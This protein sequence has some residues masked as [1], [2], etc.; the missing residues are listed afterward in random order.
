MLE[1]IP[2]FLVFA[3]VFGINCFAI[4]QKRPGLKKFLIFLG[5]VILLL[6]IGFRLNVGTDY[7]SYL[8]MY[9]RAAATPW[10]QLGTIGKEVP[11]LALFKLC[12]FVFGNGR[13]I[14]L[15]LGFFLLWPIYKI[16]KLYDYKYLAYSILVF[17]VLFLPF[18]LNGIRQGIA[19]AFM[20][21]SIVY[22]MRR[23][24]KRGIFALLLSVSFHIASLIMLP[25]IILIYV[26]EKK[27]INFTMLNILMTTLISVIIMFFLN[28]ILL[29]IGFDKYEYVLGKIN[30]E[31]VSFVNALLYLPVA[32]IALT[33]RN[34]KISDTENSVFNNLLLDGMIFCIVGS[35]ARFL[36][37]FAI[38]FLMA[39]ILLVPKQIQN[40]SEKNLR[41]LFKIL[42]I[43]YLVLLFYVEYSVLGWQEILPYQTWAFGGIG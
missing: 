34:K 4:K 24:I 35:T 22:I 20:L 33:T 17:S 38:Y 36:D 27:K 25:Y 7:N 18:S 29:D 10:N 42:L 9:N 40:I 41:L 26:H 6:F 31:H 32:L 23:N 15:V 2:Y 3:L 1:C 19:M 8:E 12:S 14:F 16:N 11:V 37:R 5:F 28:N 21:L 39:S 30:T 13:L 43:L